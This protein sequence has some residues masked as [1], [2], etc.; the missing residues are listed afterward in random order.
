MVSNRFAGHLRPPCALLWWALFSSGKNRR[1]SG[2]P[3]FASMYE[4][5]SLHK[6][7]LGT[8][9]SLWSCTV[10]TARERTRTK[11]CSPIFWRAHEAQQRLPVKSAPEGKPLQPDNNTRTPTMLLVRLVLREK[12]GLTREPRVRS[13]NEQGFTNARW[14][15]GASLQ[16]RMNSWRKNAHGHSISFS[17]NHELRNSTKIRDVTLLRRPST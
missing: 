3:R 5:P 1:G 17:N 7:T 16:R 15:T 9:T 4:Q 12:A 10:A 14:A 6:R 13:H 8:T 2:F 11:H